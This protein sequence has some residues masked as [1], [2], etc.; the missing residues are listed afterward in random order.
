MFFCYRAVTGSTQ[1]DQ[2]SILI[3][4]AEGVEQGIAPAVDR[5]ESVVR[6][7]ADGLRMGLEQGGLAEI[8]AMAMGQVD[9]IS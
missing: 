6:R 4:G 2:V 7:F 5:F 9:H 8:M 1:I 3:S